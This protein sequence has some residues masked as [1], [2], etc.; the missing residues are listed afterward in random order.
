[1]T[2]S[3]NGQVSRLGLPLV[4]AMV[5]AACSYASPIKPVDSSKSYFYGSTY[6][7][8]KVVL[9]EGTPGNPKYRIFHKGGSSF[10]SVQTIRSTAE[11]RA[12]EF[13]G[14]KG[15]VF[16]VLSE[17]SS[18]PPHVLGNFPCV[19]IVFECINKP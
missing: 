12:A 4:I 13:C 9:S 6:A 17:T 5:F 15:K 11:R 8:E 7:G 14:R 1:M 19:E 3:D 10:I 16:E 18:K 2:F